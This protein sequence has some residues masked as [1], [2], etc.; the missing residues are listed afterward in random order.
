MRK[1]FTNVKKLSI[2]NAFTKKGVHPMVGNLVWQLLF[3]QEKRNCSIVALSDGIGLVDAGTT[4]YTNVGIALDD[5]QQNCDLADEINDKVLG[6]SKK[7]AA[8]MIAGSMMKEGTKDVNF[9]KDVLRTLVDIWCYYTGDV[10]SEKILGSP[11]RKNGKRDDYCVEKFQQF[12]K[13]TCSFINN[14]D[15]N[16]LTR[17]AKVIIEETKIREDKQNDR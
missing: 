15:D 11:I 17:I 12:Q 5:Y 16:R 7:E 3:N 8:K 14:A 2:Y 4:G 10:F 6:L 9:V 1:Q 13:N